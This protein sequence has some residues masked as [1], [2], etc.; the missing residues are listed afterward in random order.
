MKYLP[1][2]LLSCFFLNSSHGDAQTTSIRIGMFDG[3]TPCQQL[4]SLLDEKTT[5]ACTKIKWRLTLFANAAQSNEG[6]YEL[7]GFV[8]KKDKPRT[9]KWT[10]VKGT[11]TDPEAVVYRLDLAGKKPLYLQKADEN[12]FFFLDDNRN[13]MTGNRDF[14]YTLNRVK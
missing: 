10:I 11:A 3:R 6:S 2:L 12:I 5:D 7:T 1:V 8:Y 14:S 9:G 13:L 4:A